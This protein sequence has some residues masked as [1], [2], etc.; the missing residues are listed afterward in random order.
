MLVRVCDT[1]I[2]A[3]LAHA[4][5]HSSKHEQRLPTTQIEQLM[6]KSG[7]TLQSSSHIGQ[8]AVVVRHSRQPTSCSWIAAGGATLAVPA[9]R[10]SIAIATVA[11]NFMTAVNNYQDAVKQRLLKL[12]KDGIELQRQ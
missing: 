6:K 9:E 3:N 8:V 11:R 5:M 10:S 4:C 2:P 1:Y 7:K 12:Q